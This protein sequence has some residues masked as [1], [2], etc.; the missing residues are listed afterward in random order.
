[1]MI[2]CVFVFTLSWLPFNTLIVVGDQYPELYNV[3]NIMYVW[4]AFHWL[5][6]SHACY[7]PAIYCWMNEKY[8][9][10]FKMMFRWLPCVKTSARPRMPTMNASLATGVSMKMTTRIDASEA[11]VENRAWSQARNHDK[12]DDNGRFCVYSVLAAPERFDRGG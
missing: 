11:N 9:H 10:G 12:N 1:M 7:N 4:F 6:M 2:V 3:P 5:A 8:R